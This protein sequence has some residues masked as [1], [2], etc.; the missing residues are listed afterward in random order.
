MLNPGGAPSFEAAAIHGVG[1]FETLKEIS[2]LALRAVRDRLAEDGERRRPRRRRKVQKKK[3]PR[4]KKAPAPE[5]RRPPRRAAEAEAPLDPALMEPLQVEFAEEDTDKVKVRAVQ[6]KGSFDIGTELRKLR[7]KSTGG[8]AHRGE[9]PRG[10]RGHAPR[11][12]AARTRARRQEIQRKATLDVSSHLLRGLTDLRFHL[13]FDRDGR[14]EILR[15][16]VR[17]TLVGTRRLEKLQRPPGPRPHLRRVTDQ[18]FPGSPSRGETGPAAPER[19]PPPAWGGI[20]WGVDER[21]GRPARSL[22]RHTTRAAPPQAQ[23]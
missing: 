22:P 2:R 23:A 4:A 20:G 15:D 14:E 10:R 13:G 19:S 21:L 3:K 6:T 11:G 1:V 5:P 9:R 18:R 8:R 7:S 12:R 17:L 16:A